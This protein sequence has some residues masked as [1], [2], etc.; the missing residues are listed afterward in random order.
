VVSVSLNSQI[1]L[2]DSYANRKAALEA[3]GLRE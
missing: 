2:L 1:V 3:A